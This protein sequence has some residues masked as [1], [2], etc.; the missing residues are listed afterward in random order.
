MA[1]QDSSETTSRMMRA[2]SRAAITERS[3][4]EGTSRSQVRNC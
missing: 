1:S 2:F 4:Q 3:R